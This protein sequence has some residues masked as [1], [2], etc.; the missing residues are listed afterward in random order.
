MISLVGYTRRAVHWLRLDSRKV[1]RPSW[2]SELDE[3]V[4][5]RSFKWNY[6]SGHCCSLCTGKPGSPRVP[7]FC[8]NLRA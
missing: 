5:S 6:R 8:L 1:N 4:G 2:G 7:L 3:S